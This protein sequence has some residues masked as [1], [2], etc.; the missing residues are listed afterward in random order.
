VRPPPEPILGVRSD[1]A[2]RAV[3]GT[4][5]SGNPRAPGGAMINAVVE[6]LT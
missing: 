5:R 1:P 6:R 4:R 3:N 2:L